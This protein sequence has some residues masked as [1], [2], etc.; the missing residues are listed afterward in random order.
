M[1]MQEGC[2]RVSC[3]RHLTRIHRNIG[4]RGAVAN[5]GQLTATAVF[6]GVSPA[7][8]RRELINQLL[9]LTA[10]AAAVAGSQQRRPASTQVEVIVL[11]G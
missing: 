2:P 9:V 5:G 6:A 1:Q 8:R 4:P 11:C 3:R 10:A 7:S